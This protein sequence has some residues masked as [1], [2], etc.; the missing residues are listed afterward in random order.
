MERRRALAWSGSLA[1]T[2]GASAIVLGSL[3]S[4][5][6]L[7][8]PPAQKTE[9]TH[10]RPA[11]QAVTPKREPGGA[12]SGPAPEGTQAQSVPEDGKARQ[13]SGSVAAR[14]APGSVPAVQRYARSPTAGRKSQ[15]SVPVSP[16]SATSSLSGPSVPQRDLG[17]PATSAAGTRATKAVAPKPNQ[18]ALC[19]VTAGEPSQ[20]TRSSL[21]KL[22]VTA[23]VAGLGDAPDGLRDHR[24]DHDG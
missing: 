7:G 11:P 3:V 13:V 8:P 21:W 22:V 12:D 15:F 20:P 16:P 19:G 23:T 14:R 24:S 1:L 2:A 10:A 5:F 9:V 4:G 6:G 17:K 18:L